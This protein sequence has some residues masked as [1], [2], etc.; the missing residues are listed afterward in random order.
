MAM[1]SVVRQLEGTLD[2]ND[3]MLIMSIALFMPLRQAIPLA[4]QIVYSRIN[5]C[6]RSTYRNA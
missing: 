3:L 2:V 6:H 5:D 4:A 1:M